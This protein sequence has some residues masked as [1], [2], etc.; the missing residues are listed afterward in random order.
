[1]HDWIREWNFFRNDGVCRGMAMARRMRL[2][3]AESTVTMSLRSVAGS[4]LRAR[5]FFLICL[6]RG[7]HGDGEGTVPGKDL[8]NTIEIMKGCSLAYSPVGGIR[9]NPD[10]WVTSSSDSEEQ[11]AGP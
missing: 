5:S 2:V 3:G 9:R 6:W 1:M 4:V 11:K 7:I 10:W 8:L